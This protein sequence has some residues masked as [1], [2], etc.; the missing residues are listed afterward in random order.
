MKNISLRHKVKKILFSFFIVCTAN[1]VSAQ[2]INFPKDS[3]KTGNQY[4]AFYTANQS[5]KK[6]QLIIAIQGCYSDGNTFTNETMPFAKQVNAALVSI[7]NKQKAFLNTAAIKAIIEKAE[8]ENQAK[9]ENIYFLGFSCNGASG[10]AYGLEYDIR[11]KGIIAFMPALDRVPFS[12]YEFKKDFPPV[13]IIT[14]SKDFAYNACKT[15]AD[16]LVKYNRRKILLI[17]IPGAPH[18]FNIAE[19]EAALTK[20]YQFINKK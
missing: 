1:F 16:I 14:G 11:F 17:D 19:K 3:V 12:Y 2:Q 8:T 13:V 7:E 15:M 6:K 5:A 18:D 9:Y 4:T 10:I 20:A